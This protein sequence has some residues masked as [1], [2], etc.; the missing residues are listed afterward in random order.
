MSA[1]GEAK[2]RRARHRA[3]A[4]GRQRSLRIGKVVVEAAA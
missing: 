4:G 2:A 1:V 3:I